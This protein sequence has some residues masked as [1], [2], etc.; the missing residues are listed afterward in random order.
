MYSL[1]YSASPPGSLASC[2]SIWT[3][4]N[5]LE[6]CKSG[7]WFHAPSAVHVVS[8]LTQDDTHLG[9]TKPAAQNKAR[10][11]SQP[12]TVAYQ[13]Q[14]LQIGLGTAIERFAL[15]LN[16]NPTP[17][18]YFSPYPED[19]LFGSRRGRISCKRQG[20]SE[21]HPDHEPAGMEKALKWAIFSA[22]DTCDQH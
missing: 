11:P 22:E 4:F 12:N 16:C 9:H 20:A 7:I 18:N 8:N 10:K 19:R 6:I 17:E 5:L 21:V 1:L 13:M 3:M 14:P 15:P 2:C